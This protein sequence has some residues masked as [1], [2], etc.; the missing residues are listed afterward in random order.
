MEQAKEETAATQPLR[1]CV[2]ALYLSR[3]L[4]EGGRPPRCVGLGMAARGA[5]PP[6]SAELAAAAAAGDFKYTCVGYAV[7]GARRADGSVAEL[8]YCSGLEVIARSPEHAG[9]AAPAGARPAPDA[10]RPPVPPAR[11]PIGGVLPRRE[12]DGYVSGGFNTADA[13][14]FLEKWQRSANKIIDRMKFNA[15]YMGRL[16]IGGASP[17]PDR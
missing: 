8:P 17:R 10:P 7:H 2:G 3:A 4:R 6:P 1:C 14:L 13:K 15:R 16:I 12:E 5:T 11:E 9:A